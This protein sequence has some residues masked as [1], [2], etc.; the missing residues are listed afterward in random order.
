MSSRRAKKPQL[1]D[2]F[3]VMKYLVLLAVIIIPSLYAGGL[4]WANYDPTGRIDTVP[5]A[6]VNEDQP[7]QP[8][9]GD[10]L[11]LG[12]DITDELLSNNSTSNFNWR[13]MEADTASKA[14]ED[15]E[16]MAV[17]TIPSDFSANV[18]S[19]SDNDPAAARKAQL[20]IATNDGS[21]LIA[22]NIANVLGTSVADRLK[23][24]VTDE[25]LQNIYAG[26]TTVHDSLGEAADG[27]SQLTDGAT[28]AKDGSDELVLGLNDLKSGADSLASGSSDL[29]AGAASARD[30]AGSLAQGAGSLATGANDVNNGAGALDDGSSKVAE[31]ASSIND[32]A[33]RLSEGATSAKEGAS[34][35]SAGATSGNEGA[36]SL[37]TGA[38]SV[39]EGAGSL[40]TGL[41]ELNT[42]ISELPAQADA[43]AAGTQSLA[44][45]S[46]R[47]RHLDA[48]TCV[49]PTSG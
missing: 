26:F 40:A 1:N 11:N 28:S 33:G 21:N 31:G 23:E 49:T 35:L 44:D 22:G 12:A 32:G 3:S 39:N 5:A 8:S 9:E 47:L 15:G 6:I 38:A 10:Q 24:Q 13:V 37:A 14:L 16:I 20:D 43:L 2:R 19:V 34:T 45:G 29:A 41:S 42:G 7:A 17:L 18:V 36:G 4:T 48:G 30:G 27:A 25:Y 46:P